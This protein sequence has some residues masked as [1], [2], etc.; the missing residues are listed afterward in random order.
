[1]LINDIGDESPSLSELIHATEVNKY[2]LD[3]KRSQKKIHVAIVRWII[4]SYA[5]I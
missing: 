2:Y 1:M 3:Y 4:L 5:F